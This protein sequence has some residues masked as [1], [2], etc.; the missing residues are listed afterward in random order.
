METQ[1]Q[2]IVNLNHSHVYEKKVVRSLV[3]G[4]ANNFLCL[5]K[6]EEGTNL[7]L[8]FKISKQ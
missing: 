8:E 6:G 1:D 5:E 7:A 3:K 2:Q 4:Q